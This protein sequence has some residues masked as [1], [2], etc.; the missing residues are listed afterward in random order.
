[1]A[2][3]AVIFGF[4]RIAYGLR[5]NGA[6]YSQYPNGTHFDAIRTTP[7]LELGAV[8]EPSEVRR[9]QAL[10]AGVPVVV[11]DV[12]DLPDPK[13]YHVAIF[14]NPPMGRL[15][16]LMAL[17]SLRAA[18]FEKPFALN[19]QEAIALKAEIEKRNIAAQI[20]YMRRSDHRFQFLASGGL[21]SYI[22]PVTGG[23][24]RYGHGLYNNASHEINIL[25]FL[26][27]AVS[28]VTAIGTKWYAE[29]LPL[30]GDCNLS[31]VAEFNCGA[32]IFF[33]ASDFSRCRE[34][35]V[36]LWG[37]NGSLRII[38]ELTEFYLRPSAPHVLLPDIK[39]LGTESEVLPGNSDSFCRMYRSIVSA[40]ENGTEVDCT[41]GASF[42][43]DAV[44]DAA[45]ESAARGGARVLVA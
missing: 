19:R 37:E 36:E 35:S 41:L 25:L 20:G 33:D 40:I 21:R 1:L 34:T 27:G 31:F 18:L 17:P 9:R 23:A 28:A 8:V 26:I 29:K 32:K 4:G 7:G 14:A 39:G 15:A 13:S 45:L 5:E 10:D 6:Y 38:R 24:A 43:T 44:I 11:A 12:F 3:R 22:G 30:S 42:A 16:A 2:F